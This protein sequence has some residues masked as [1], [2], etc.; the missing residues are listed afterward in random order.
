V[1]ICMPLKMT[2]TIPGH[3]PSDRC[4]R[5]QNCWGREELLR[6]EA[7]WSNGKPS[8]LRIAKATQQ[9]LSMRGTQEVE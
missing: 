4:E 3:K 8:P 6:T 2:E 1:C 5:K 7:K 9:Q